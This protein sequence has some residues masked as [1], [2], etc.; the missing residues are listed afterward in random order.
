MSQI[1][2]TESIQIVQIDETSL[3]RLIA[4]EPID[5]G[6]LRVLDGALPPYKTVDRALTQLGLGTP[7]LWCVPFLIICTSHKALLGA[8]G[9]KTAPVNGSVEISYGIARSGRGRGVATL[10]I[11]KLL[12]LA[13]ASGQ[14]QQVVAHILPDNVASSRLASRL[15]FI[16]GPLVVDGDGERVVPW[17]CRVAT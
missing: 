4:S 9:F 13:A 5:I 1:A 16:A 15:G 11:S 14:V 10:A 6:D 12:Q 7:P 8:C 17:V 3:R 2:D